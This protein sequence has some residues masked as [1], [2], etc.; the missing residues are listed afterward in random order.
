MIEGPGYPGPFCLARSLFGQVRCVLALIYGL[1][2]RRAER[3]YG[4]Y[5]FSY[6]VS[7]ARS[8]LATGR[9]GDNVETLLKN[10]E[11]SAQFVAALHNQSSLR[12][13]RVCTLL[14]C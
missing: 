9:S 4:M 5:V 10:R 14:A 8:K 13:D 2:S 12:D 3:D 1:A 11:N 7:G 6:A